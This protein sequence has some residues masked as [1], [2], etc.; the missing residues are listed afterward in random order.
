MQDLRPAKW[1]QEDGE[2]SVY[3]IPLIPVISVYEITCLGT[4]T[5]CVYN[6]ISVLL[7][8]YFAAIAH[9]RILY[10]SNCLNLCFVAHDAL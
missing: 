9:F 6:V 8:L 7:Y 1:G 2:C 10:L 4:F 3:S 5:V